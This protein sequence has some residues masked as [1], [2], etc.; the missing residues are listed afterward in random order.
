[1]REHS[2]GNH[3]LLNCLHKCWCY[4]LS[5]LKLVIINESVNSLVTK[6]FVKIASETI[7]RVFPCKAEEHIIDE[8]SG[9][10]CWY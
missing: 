9:G 6:S 7:A 3:R 1:V 5:S 8:F 4:F 10:D 2:D